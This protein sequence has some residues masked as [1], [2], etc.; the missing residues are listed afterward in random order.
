MAEN[1]GTH[2]SYNFRKALRVVESDI[3]TIK[4]NVEGI[5]EICNALNKIHDTL[6]DFKIIFSRIA[7]YSMK[8]LDRIVIGI[9]IIILLAMGAK[10]LPN[11]ISLIK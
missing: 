6:E 9:F 11:L 4:A 2:E 7:N 10:E 1:N 8:L 3:Q 5:S